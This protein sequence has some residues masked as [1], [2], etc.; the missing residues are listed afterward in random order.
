M[1]IDSISASVS[2]E[3]KDLSTMF[4]DLYKREKIKDL[5]FL[6]S[7]MTDEKRQF[8]DRWEEGLNKS[9]KKNYFNKDD[10]SLLLSFGS[11]LGITDGKGQVSNCELHKKL[12]EKQ[13]AEAEI[14]LKEKS[15]VNTALSIL[16]GSLFAVFVL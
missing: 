3:E 9:V 15:K 4:R 10:I 11:S 6:K 13:L 1:L 16:S 8:F 14:N 5:Y 7:V 12:L 2:F